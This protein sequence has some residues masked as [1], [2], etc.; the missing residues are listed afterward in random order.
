MYYSNDDGNIGCWVYNTRDGVTPFL[1]LKDGV[2]LQH[3]HWNYDLQQPNYKPIKGD[4]VF[5]DC[6]NEEIEGWTREAFSAH[7][8]HFAKLDKE[9]I[10]R[11][12]ILENEE[13]HHP[14]FA[15]VDKD[16]NYVL[17]NDNPVPSNDGLFDIKTV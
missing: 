2:Q 10:V 5:R 3:R 7:P 9:Q 14:C 8:E 4:L 11:N 1:I 16:G 12:A 6:T 15:I 13:L 17:Y